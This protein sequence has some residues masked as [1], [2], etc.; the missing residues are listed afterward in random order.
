MSELSH[1]KVA[2][3]LDTMPASLLE[4]TE[5]YGD[6]EAVEFVDKLIELKNEYCGGGE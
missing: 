4:I 3:L 1:V 2:K 6:E 5:L